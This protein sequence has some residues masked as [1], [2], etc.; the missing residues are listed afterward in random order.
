MDG[1]SA[2][3]DRVARIPSAGSGEPTPSPVLAGGFAAVQAASASLVVVLAPV[4]AGWVT[5]GSRATWFQ[6]VQI[7]LDTWLL[8]HHA[9]IVLPGGTVG[10]FPIGLAAVALTT[11]WLAGRRLARVLDPK[12]AAIEAGVSRARPARVPVRAL[13]GF[14]A[15][16]ALLGLLAGLVAASPAARPLA[17]QAVLG[18]GLTA[19]IAGTAG[20][21]AYRAGGLRA[22]LEALF[23]AVR[24]PPSGRRWL[25]LG[26]LA[27]AVLLAAAL[28]LTAGAVVAG[29]ERVLGLHRALATGAWG[30]AVLVGLQVAVLPNLVVWAGAFLAGPGFAVGAGTMVTPQETVLGP[31]PALPVLGALPAPGPQPRWATLVVLVPVLA[32]AVA[33]AA[34]VRAR[35]Q[36]TPWGLAADCAGLAL[37]AGTGFGLLAWLSGGPAGPGRLEVTGPVPW[38]AAGVL[39][40]ECGAGALVAVAAG[41]AWRGVVGHWSARPGRRRRPDP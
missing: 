24:L 34:A 23:E 38:L 13:A 26:A 4:V 2:L 14:V 16:Y 33:G 18:C 5:S 39:A 12:A 27:L 25:R 22:G 35:R 40:A 31:L 32:G 37:A 41:L 1:M 9:S 29:S 21:A 7:G 3:L 17:T 20:A 30:G 10:L 15:C 8:A 28:L 6:A 36:A 19:A 11:C